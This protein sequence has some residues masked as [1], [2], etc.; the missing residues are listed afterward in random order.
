MHDTG[1]PEV[2]KNSQIFFAVFS[3]TYWVIDRV[4]KALLHSQWRA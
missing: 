1:F 2:N 4:R 3:R